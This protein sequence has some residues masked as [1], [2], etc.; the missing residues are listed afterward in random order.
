MVHSTVLVHV[1]RISDSILRRSLRLFAVTLSNACAVVRESNRRD[2]G[3]RWIDKSGCEGS[4]CC[5]QNYPPSG[6]QNCF[7][8]AGMLTGRVVHHI[9][10]CSCLLLKFEICLINSSGL[11]RLFHCKGLIL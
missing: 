9:A 5:Y 7:H 1:I 2:C 4:G 6:K 11:Y 8:P 10:D 3:D